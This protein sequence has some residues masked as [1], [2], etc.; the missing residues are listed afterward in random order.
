MSATERMI[1]YHLSRLKDK[2]PDVRIKSIQELALLQATQA[3]DALEEIFRTDDNPLV[4][5]AAQEA[6][7]TLYLL[8]KAQ[9]KNNNPP[10]D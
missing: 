9:E 3:F 10:G 7:K 6:G 1:A 5:K 8:R 2:R 4:R